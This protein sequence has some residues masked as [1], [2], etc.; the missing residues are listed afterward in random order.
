MPAADSFGSLAPAGFYV[1][2][3]VGFAFPLVEHNHLPEAWVREYTVSGF[4]VHDPMMAWAYRNCGIVRS[5]TLLADDVQGVL[6]LAQGH[7]L[8]HG[9]AA[10]HVDGAGAGD[11]SL[12]LFF[13]SDRDFTDEELD[14]LLVALRAAHLEHAPPSNLTAAELETLELVKNGMLMKEMANVLGI[15]ESAIKQRLQS[16]RRKLKARTGS[17]AAARATMLGMI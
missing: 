16:A 6:G 4:L 10:A 5:A 11:R 13:R 17:Q 9:A 1:A 3:R 2:I 8:I 7:G 14:A 15:S 12:A